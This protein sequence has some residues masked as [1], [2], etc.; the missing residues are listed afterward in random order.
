MKKAN[1][2]IISIV[3]QEKLQK[4][5]GDKESTPEEKVQ[6]LAKSLDGEDWKRINSK[7]Y[8]LL[9]IT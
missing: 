8:V 1:D 2:H 3:I 5:N 7:V 4:L 6:H 9:L